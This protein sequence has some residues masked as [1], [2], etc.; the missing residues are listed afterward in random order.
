MF[1]EHQIRIS[2][3]YLKGH[4]TLNGWWKFSFAI[5][6]MIYILKYTEKENVCFKLYYFPPLLYF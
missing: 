5:T 3:W 1:L 2:E 4:M 6:G